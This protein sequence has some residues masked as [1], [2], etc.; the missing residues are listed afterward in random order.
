MIEIAH[1]YES[2]IALG[3]MLFFRLQASLGLLV[4]GLVYFLMIII[5]NSFARVKWQKTFTSSWLVA[6]IFGVGYSLSVAK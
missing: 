1:W 5:D 6:L 3:I 2:T 4:V